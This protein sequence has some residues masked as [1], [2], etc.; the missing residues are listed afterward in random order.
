LV[1]RSNRAG[2][3]KKEKA[4]RMRDFVKIDGTR[5]RLNADAVAYVIRGGMGEKSTTIVLT[6]GAEIQVRGAPGLICH[7]LEV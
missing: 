6:N 7:S 3:A 2:S 1:A 4:M 5:I